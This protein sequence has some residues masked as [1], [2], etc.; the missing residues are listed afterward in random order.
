MSV[1][2]NLIDLRHLSQR[3]IKLLTHFDRK[4]INWISDSDLILYDY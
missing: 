2:K 3:K 1:W 4:E